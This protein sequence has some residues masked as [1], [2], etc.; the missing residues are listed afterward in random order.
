MSF[1]GFETTLDRDN[2]NTI[3][4][5]LAVYT[6][7]EESY[8]GLGDALEEGGDELNDETFG[9]TGAVGKD[10]DFAGHIISKELPLKSQ[11]LHQPAAPSNGT[12]GFP[13]PENV[14]PLD[15]YAQPS[16]LQPIS[17]ESLWSGSGANQAQQIP[18]TDQWQRPSH[19]AHKSTGSKSGFSPFDEPTLAQHVA[20]TSQP[21]IRTLQEI[22]AEMRASAVQNRTPQ[23]SFQQPVTTYAPPLENTQQFQHQF[24]Q[25]IP[26]PMVHPTLDEHQFAM[27]QLE[28]RMRAHQVSAEPQQHYRSQSPG[29]AFPPSVQHVH[30]EQFHQPQARRH[31]QQAPMDYAA[32]QMNQT[33]IVQQQQQEHLQQQMHLRQMMNQAPF[34]HSLAGLAAQ[35]SGQYPAGLPIEDDFIVDP[36][37]GLG[38]PNALRSSVVLDQEQRN[39]VMGEAMRKIMEA[40]QMEEKRRR[41]AQKMARM[42]R[43]NDLMTQSDK[44]FITRIQ[45]S[46]LVTQDPY[47]EDF[48]AQ[49]FGAI[50]RA[51][52]GVSTG[53]KSVLKIGGGGVGLGLPG[54]RGKRLLPRL[55]RHLPENKIS[56]LTALFVACFYQLDVVRD[57]PILDDVLGQ[58]ATPRWKEV[59]LNTDA[60]LTTVLP[61]ITAVL[62]GT[63]LRL[64]TGFLNIMLGTGK[65]A[66]LQIAKSQ[67]GVALLTAFM[68]RADQLKHE[69]N[70]LDGT[71]PDD[72]NKWQA[73]F[74]SLLNFLQGS[75]VSLFPSRRVLSNLPQAPLN[76]I[77]LDL[78]LA[79]QIVWQLL[80]VLAALGTQ[81]Q[82]M[83]MVAELRDVILEIVQSVHS[84]WIPD[85]REA[86]L[87]LANV[88]ILLRAI[89]LDD[90][91]LVA[92]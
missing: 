34:Q 12:T 24:Q 18:A 21:R 81:A 61:A 26:P 38:D 65:D 85:E 39:A 28:R 23:T 82:Q 51:R 3:D 30:G 47:T 20:S 80:A 89:G 16:N 1:F 2:K 79:D 37:L 83:T 73:A 88:N 19:Q 5:D 55:I 10:F 31:I 62:A 35:A 17:L 86:A 59:S 6:W 78:D 50:L 92:N 7:G 22:E 87:K 13:R 60:F 76:A 70:E 45:V 56:L 67:P 90:S 4:E 72:W 40:E 42:A 9:G 84:G 74:D 11:Q 33:R 32:Q 63:S 53:E 48:Y 25:P 71:T 64:L 57:A 46:Q 54:Q 27:Q 52:L 43:Y 58:G 75:I 69:S 41:R 29:L 36:R 49:V 44:D 66:I 15:V 8:D 68:G 77:P 91:L 14:T